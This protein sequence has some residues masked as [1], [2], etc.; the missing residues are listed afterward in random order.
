MSFTRRTKKMKQ[1]I[2]IY[3]HIEPFTYEKQIPTAHLELTPFIG[4]EIQ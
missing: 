2:P 4:Q 3:S 1:A